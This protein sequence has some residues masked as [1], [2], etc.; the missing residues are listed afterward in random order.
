MNTRIAAIVTIA[1]VAAAANADDLLLIDLSVAN[2]ITIS[3]TSGLSSADVSGADVTGVY[4]DNFYGM[5][6]DS[7]SASYLSG[8]L[9]TV[10]DASDGSPSLF[11]GGAGS[12]SG[13][14]F[15]SWATASTV[16]FTA[17][18]Q[19]FSGSATWAL[20]ANE[21]ANMLAG[22]L[23]GDLYFPADTADDIAGATAI[24]TWRVIPA[25]TGLAVLGLGGLVATRRRR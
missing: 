5:A 17:G 16:S 10:G 25:P 18:S 22:N 9:S 3:A 2:Q 4:M 7:L 11:R 15:W 20:D 12:D 24:G 8:D 1:G 23:S 6:G 21:Y 19:A 14:N 13:L